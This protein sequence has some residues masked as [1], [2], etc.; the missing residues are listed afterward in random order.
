MA[1][2]LVKVL[3]FR[4]VNPVVVAYNVIEVAKDKDNRATYSLI[5]FWYFSCHLMV[6]MDGAKTLNA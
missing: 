3:P 2:N 5:P 1:L 4:Y 6:W